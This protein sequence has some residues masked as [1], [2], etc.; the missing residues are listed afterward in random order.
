M[1]EKQAK[2][3]YLDELEKMADGNED[4]IEKIRFAKET[5]NQEGQNTGIRQYAQNNNTLQQRVQITFNRNQLIPMNMQ[6]GGKIGQALGF[7]QATY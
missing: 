2:L 5:V 6:P 1:T 3:D 7:Q 4:E